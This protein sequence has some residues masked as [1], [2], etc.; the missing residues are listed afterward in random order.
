MGVAAIFCAL[1]YAARALLTGFFEEKLN[2]ARHRWVKKKNKKRMLSKRIAVPWSHT[3][4]CT[5]CLHVICAYMSENPL[6]WGKKT[7]I[8]SE[9]H[10]LIWGGINQFFSP[11]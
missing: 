5:T 3:R 9:P 6:K 4:E 10:F 2:L 7:E 11:R 8:D 1:D